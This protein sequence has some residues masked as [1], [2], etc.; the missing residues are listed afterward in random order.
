MAF[1]IGDRGR[2]GD[3]ALV[4]RGCTAKKPKIIAMT[5]ML[6][7]T[8]RPSG[9]FSTGSAREAASRLREEPVACNDKKILP[10]DKPGTR[11]EA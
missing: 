2:T 7:T 3:L 5:K 9:G 6:W 10:H 4:R 11:M 1:P 8:C